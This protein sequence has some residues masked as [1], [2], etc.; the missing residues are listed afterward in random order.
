MLIEVDGIWMSLFSIKLSLVLNYLNISVL[1]LKEKANLD[2]FNF[3]DLI[4]LGQITDEAKQRIC[5]TLEMTE[6]EIL[7]F[8]RKL[9]K[10]RAL[11][12]KD[13]PQGSDEESDVHYKGTSLP[14][15]KRRPFSPRPRSSRPKHW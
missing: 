4:V 14:K 15:I 5:I 7:A 3:V 9:T 8:P 6:E 12:P 13:E 11:I 2:D 1:Q 10:V